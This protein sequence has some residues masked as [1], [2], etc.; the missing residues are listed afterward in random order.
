MPIGL[1]ANRHADITGTKRL[2]PCGEE[3]IFKEADPA[4]LLQ[5]DEADF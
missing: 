4:V 1:P 2:P 3:D 5:V